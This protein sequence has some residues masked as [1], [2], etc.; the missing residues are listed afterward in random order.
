MRIISLGGINLGKVKSDL[1]DNLSSF[2]QGG[3]RTIFHQIDQLGIKKGVDQIGI[4]KFITQCALFAAGSGV[5]TG[6]GGLSTMLIGVPLDIINLI[7]QQFRVT[8]A[9]SYYNTGKYELRFEDFFKI[10]AAS[11][12]VDTSM[13]VSKGVMEEVAQKLLLT[14]GSKT[15]K[16]LIPVVGGVIGGSINYLFIKRVASSLQT[17]QP[18]ARII[19]I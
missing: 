16:R 5:I 15:A 1:A 11:L 2:S 14:L 10:V 7:T 8:L 18:E 12:K 19:R 3:F 9:I 6:A 13:S 17:L 4:D